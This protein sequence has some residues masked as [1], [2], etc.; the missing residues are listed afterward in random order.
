VMK[1]TAYSVLLPIYRNDNPDFL[2]VAIDSILNQSFQADEILIAVDGYI[3]DDLKKVIENYKKS[4]EDLFTV[5]YYLENEGL[6]KLL[7]KTLLLCRNEYIARMDADDF[8]LPNRIEK[9]FKLLESRNDINIVGTNV[10]EFFNEFNNVVAKVVLPEE[11]KDIYNFAKRRC[12]IRHSSLLFK[13]SDVL[14]VGNYS[15]EPYIQNY[16]Q[17]YDLI[18]KLLIKGFNIYN[19][20]EP[21][22]KMRVN[23]DFYNRRGGINYLKCVHK[24]KIKFLKLGFYSLSDFII[25]F[26]GQAIVIL[27]PGS[28]R[29][30]VYNKFLRS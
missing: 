17:D 8:S 3:N 13:K 22:V 6:G 23:P 24:A 9:Q 30:F 21:L 25:S 14:S 12:P 18:V 10:D 11:P 20:Q 5:C 15:T 27:M 1:T 26:F 7:N 16:M 29:T 2:K 19:I 4:N 28:I